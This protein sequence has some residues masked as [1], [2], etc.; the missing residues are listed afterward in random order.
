MASYNVMINDKPA[1]DGLY[2]VFVRLT[3]Q[4]KHRKFS[5]DFRIR[6]QDFN[7]RAKPGKWIRPSE[8][9]HAIYND[10][11]ENKIAE[12]RELFET[13]SKDS[14]GAIDLIKEA[15]VT[16]TLE[17]A[18]V[19]GISLGTYT[20]EI[21]KNKYIEHSFGYARQLDSKIKRFVEFIGRDRLLSSIT[22][23]DVERYRLE[24]L[25]Q[26]LKGSSINDN[27]K[28][29]DNNVF[30]PAFNKEL[31]HRNPFAGIKSATTVKPEKFRLSDSQIEKL[32]NIVLPQDGEINW[33][34]HA[35]NMYLLSYYN[36]G[37]RIKDTLQLRKCFIRNGRLDYEMDKTGHR[38]SIKLN[39]KSRAILALYNLEV[40]ED[41]D[42]IFPGLNRKADYARYVTYE[43]KK[44]MPFELSKALFNAISSKAAL[45]NKNLGF[46][47]KKLGFKGRMSFHTA[48]HS[49]ADKGRRIMK[50]NKNVTLD[51]VRLSL[52][53]SKLSTTQAYL[54]SFDYDSLDSA[55][56]DIFAEKEPHDGK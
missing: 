12:V 7:P 28:R 53:H 50:G 16:R 1:R 25:E 39:A 31:I 42:Y 29:V 47:S 43:E 54:D 13:I 52:G 18:N 22:Y 19:T 51:D 55:M 23:D 26:K 14:V 11:I 45:I 48:R 32:E 41:N 27:L 4:R 30:T 46:L 36:A 10:A 38:K 8:K 9:S 35:R 21:I 24:L 3:H 20:D 6:Q 37:I 5:L 15:S 49:F 44:K 2:S 34:Y 17:T 33:L 40:L 56:D